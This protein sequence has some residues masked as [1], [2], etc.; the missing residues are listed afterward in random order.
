MAITQKEAAELKRQKNELEQKRLA[1][2]E[3][4]KNHRGASTDEL[5]ETADQLR[6]LSDQID[7]INEQLT[8]APEDNKRGLFSQRGGELNE[9][10]FRSSAKYRDAFYRSYLNNK[11][12]DE[13]A[14]IMSYGKRAITDMNGGSVTSGA[15][16]LVPQTT[17]DKVYAV[18]KQYGR[19]YSAITKYGFTGDVALPIGT[20]GAPTTNSDGTV[21][22]NFSFTEV[23]IQQ[24]A[25]VATIIVK[26][27]LLRNSIPA[28][29]QYLAEEVGKYI[30][31]QLE[32][33]VLNG[34]ISPTSNFLGI[35]PAIK[36]TPSAAKTY[37]QMDWQQIGEILASV[38]SPYGD[39]GT[40]VMKRYTFFTRFF[41]LT[42]AA[43][44]PL[45]TVT[46]VQGGP[47]S[48]NYLIAGMPVIFS[49]QMPDADAVLYGDLS[50]YIVNESESFTLES[51]SSERFSSDETVW[52]GKVYSGGKPLFAKDTFTYWT[53]VEAPTT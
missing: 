2:K 50:T 53:F 37:S 27:L 24:Q 29:E 23:K 42:D 4:V 22:L 36:E 15:E 17:L 52:R 9:E 3:K 6:T 44:K 40:W 46:P 21:T 41:S 7:N 10:N 26:N 20:A 25:V 33:S 19:L 48:S 39:Q 45:V 31:L 16:Y 32:N 30:G 43:G 28:F 47:G 38:E 11:I 1:L 18:I 51:N 12:S 5:N 8:E 35:I 14:E 34:T 13:D 49:S